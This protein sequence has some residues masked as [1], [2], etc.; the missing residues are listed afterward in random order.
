MAFLEV[1][2]V[3]G[4]YKVELAAALAAAEA[5]S[6]VLG[7]SSN[8]DITIADDEVSRRHLEL[9]RLGDQWTVEDL[10]ARNG[11]QVNGDELMKRAVLHTGDEIRVGSTIISYRDYSD[12]GSTTG[13][14]EPAPA[15]TKTEHAVLKELCRKYFSKSRTKAPSTREEMANA[16]CVGEPAIQAHLGNLY[17]KFDIVGER[18]TKRELLAE[19]VMDRGVITRRDYPADEG[20]TT[21]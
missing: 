10:G 20:P 18:G 1:Y 7:R 3:A 6:L 11:T 12:A 17:V 9:R 2:D 8:V 21:G 16:L 13:K 14:Q 4:S 5:D 19:K 15:I